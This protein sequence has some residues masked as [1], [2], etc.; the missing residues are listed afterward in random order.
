M[1]LCLYA[2]VRILKYRKEDLK[3]KR[4][5]AVL[6]VALLVVGLVACAGQPVA[7]PAPPPTGGGTTPAET[8]DAPAGPAMVVRIGHVSP[9]HTARHIGMLALQEY[10]MEALPGQVD[11]QIFP[12][13]QLG[14]A[15]ELAQGLQTG[16]LEIALMGAGFMGGFEPALGIVDVP[17]IW[18]ASEDAVIAL[19]EEALIP[20][21][22]YT[23]DHTGMRLLDYWFEEFIVY[24]STVP[25]RTLADFHGVRI[26]TIPNPIQM[27]M[28]EALGATPVAMD[29]GELYQGLLTGIVDG[30]G[31]PLSFMAGNML[32][33]VH[34]YLTLSFHGIGG[35]YIS[36]SLQWWES[37]P[38]EWQEIFL[39]GIDAGRAAALAA[40]QI[41][42]Q[43]A[44]DA[45]VE[46]GVTFI[47]LDPAERERWMEALAPVADVY[48]EMTGRQD[49]LD[50]VRA[51]TARRS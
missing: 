44:W 25:L 20:E 5:F 2:A 11:I 24:G 22:R 41:E 32:Q 13:A 34:N 7:T 39:R 43:D 40:M 33:E 26:R 21:L 9:T 14:P 19:M 31:N 4:L 27:A 38:T 1:K 6:L 42:A 18:P 3:M 17:G 12:A 37:L 45:Y 35:N 10:V 28:V 36:A 8:P 50:L 23:L 29:P 16:S 46:A 48:V 47:E 15:L 30:N 51:E 49:I